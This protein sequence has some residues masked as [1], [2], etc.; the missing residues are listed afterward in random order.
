[1]LALEQGEP[2]VLKPLIHYTMAE[3]N[4]QRTKSCGG[5]MEREQGELYTCGE[6]TELS[7]GS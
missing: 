2:K 1:M 6:E 7:K 4:V 5:H 3:D